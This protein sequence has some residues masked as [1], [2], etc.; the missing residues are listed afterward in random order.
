[1]SL[2]T[3]QP[4]LSS[5]EVRDHAVQA[6][7]FLTRRGVDSLDAVLVLGSGLGDFVETGERMQIDCV[8]PYADIPWFPQAPI[9]APSVVGHSGRLVIATLDNQKRV[10]IMQGRFHFYEGYS[11]TQVTFPIRIFRELKAP[12]LIVTNAAGGINPG[13][14]PGTLMLIRDHINLMGDNPLIGQ[15]LNDWGP[16]FPD[17][18]NAY[19]TEL[20]QRAL[21]QA[22]EAGI[23]LSE[24][25]YAAMS[26]PSYETPAEVRMLKTLGAD[27]AGMSTVPE[28]IVARHMGMK[29]LGISCI[30]N[31]AAGI[32][33]QPLSHDE[34]VETGQRVKGPFSTLIRRLLD[35]CTE[36]IVGS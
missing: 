13:F 16:R 32:S 29:V 12:V 19:D 8:L 25:V 4:P 23:P 24:G 11:M 35:D 20:A 22:S 15:N 18:S 14:S 27:A 26:G 34:V 21:V 10:A 31:L 30:T 36:T 2:P 6:A 7:N 17:M 33:Q 3:T 28:V 9:G 5:L 1:M